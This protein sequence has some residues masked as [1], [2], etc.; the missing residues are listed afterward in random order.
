MRSVRIL[1]ALEGRGV[2]NVHAMEPVGF[3]KGDAVVIPASL[4]EFRVRPQ[5]RIEFLKASVPGRSLPEPE[6]RM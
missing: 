6:T 3:G 5:G 2:V 4:G 1:V